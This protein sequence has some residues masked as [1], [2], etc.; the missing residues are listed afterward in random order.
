MTYQLRREETL[1]AQQLVA[2]LHHPA[3]ADKGRRAQAILA[4]A[5]T[6]LVDAQALLGQI[7]L[8]GE[9]IQ[10]DAQL[11]RTWFQAAASQ[12]HA[13]ARN[14]LGRCC[15]HGWGGPVDLLQAATHYRLAS[16]ADLD[17]GLYNF[18]NLFATGRGVTLDQHQALAC[19]RRAAELGHAKSMNLLG[20]YLEQGE[21]CPRDLPSAWEWY[22]R[23]AESGDF[24]GQFSHAAVLLNQGQFTAAMQW[25]EKALTHG[26]LN[27]LRV[28]TQS[29]SAAGDARLA[30]LTERYAARLEHLNAA[31]DD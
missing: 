29:L 16:A 4:A 11:A 10:R 23:S 25:F 22:R 27:F 7:L 20:R 14:M 26:N 13:M 24:R 31:V 12:G 2:L 1:D 21:Y 3:P 15:E 6:G 30:E 17:W 5:R 19:Y 9:G 28:A 8:D 18:A